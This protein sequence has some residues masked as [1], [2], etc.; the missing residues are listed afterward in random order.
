MRPSQA[1]PVCLALAAYAVAMLSGLAA[2]NPASHTLLVALVALIPGYLL[3]LAIGAVADHVLDEF[4]V[5]Y[6]QQHPVPD[7]SEIE[8]SVDDVEI[9]EDDL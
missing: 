3:G 1:I 5:H 7:V 2:G 4:T 9:V 8:S 6:L